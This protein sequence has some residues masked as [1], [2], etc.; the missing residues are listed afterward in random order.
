[1]LATAN[2]EIIRVDMG[3]RWHRVCLMDEDLH[4]CRSAVGGLQRC[5]LVRSGGMIL[6]GQQR[7]PTI[8]SAGRD[9]L[10]ASRPS[11]MATTPCY[12]PRKQL[13]N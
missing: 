2:E 5:S 6:V 8:P 11:L 1:M 10:H 3:G 13:I 4:P 7:L 12:C 9:Q